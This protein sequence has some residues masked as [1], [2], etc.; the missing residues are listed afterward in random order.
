MKTS[1]LSSFLSAS[2]LSLSLAACGGSGAG[3]DGTVSGTVKGLGNGLNLTLQNNGVDTLVVTS[4]GTFA[5]PTK[6]SSL[7]PF[8]VTIAAQPIGQFCTLTRAAGVIPTD[9]NQADVTVVACAANSLGVVVS[10]LAA[11]STVTLNNAAAQIVVNTNGVSTFAGILTGGTGFNLAV[12][13]QPTTQVCTL[14]N[15]SGNITAGVQSLAT[16]NCI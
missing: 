11:G 14:S 7:G 2:L 9:G 16:L 8:S 15:A 13:V 6:L 5:F 1:R 3:S 12:A 10:G 4:N